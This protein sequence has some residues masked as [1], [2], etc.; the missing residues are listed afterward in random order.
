MSPRTGTGLFLTLFTTLALLVAPAFGQET[1]QI[2]TTADSDYYGFD[3]RT[4]RDV[5]LD[6]CKAACLADPA[7]RAF[8]FNTSAKWCFLKSDYNQLN[9]FPGAIAGKVETALGEP[10]IG[11][12][13]TLSFVPA[14]V[15]GDAERLRADVLGK[16]NAG[17]AGLAFLVQAAE[18]AMASNDPRAALLNYQNALAILPDDTAIWAGL[19]AAANAVV[20]RSGESAYYFQRLGTGAAINAYLLS[21]TAS[22]RA[23]ALNQL[24][25]ALEKRSMFRP[26][27]TAYEESLALVA[28]P[29]IQAL[30]ADL[31]RRK[32]FRVVEHTIDSD[33]ATPR[34]CVQFSED[35]VKSGIDYAQ[36]V[37]V[38]NAP[39]TAVDKG[40]RQLCV[41]GL[42]HGGRYRIVIRQGLPAAIG[43][44]I[45]EPVALDIYVRDRSPSIRFT[46][47]NFV[48]PDSARRGIPLVS[49]NTDR[50]EI[51]LYRIGARS[52]ARLMGES[53]FLRQL[54]AYE[55]GS[56][57]DDLGAPV[58]E[59]TINIAADRNKEVITSFPVDEAVPEREP[60]VYVMT[61]V[62]ENDRRD[63][64][65]SRA[66]QWF[67]VSD[68]GLA[69]FAGEDGL[70]VFARSLDSAAP[71]AGVTL[72]LVARN[73]EVLATAR[74][75]DD[76][77]ARFDAGLARGENGLAPAVITAETSEDFVFL[78]M[79]RA[80]FDLSDRGVTGRPSP[81]ALDVY[82]WTERG[83]YRAG[84]TVHAAALARNPA[85]DAID[86]LPLTFIF[87]RPDGV[88][89]RRIVSNG[90][91]LGGHA[92]DLELTDNAMRGT[93]SLR[94]HADPKEPPLSEK[95]FLVE[96][97]VPDRIAFDLA[98]DREE[99]ALG[100]A[101]SVEV[102]GRYLYGAP[103]EG[104]ALEGQLAI[105]RSREWARFPGY[106]FGLEDEEDVEDVRVALDGLPRTGSDGKAA[107]PVEL[108][109][110]PSTTQLLSA[111]ISVRMVEAGG[112]AVE[113]ALEL[114]VKPEGTSLGLK[115]EFEGGQVPE[116]SIAS[117]RVIAVGPDGARLDAAGLSWSL[118][119]INRQYQWYRSGNSWRYE[120]I[121]S[122]SLVEEGSIDATAAGEAQISV[123]VD[124][125]R[126]RLEIETDDPAGPVTSVEFS[127]GWFVAARSTET[128]DGLEIALD[129]ESYRVG[130]TA[131]LKIES[132]FA[133]EALVTVGSE[134]LISTVTAAVPADGATI[135]IPVTE[136]FGAGTYVTATLFRPGEA[137]E[138]RL[139]MRAI[140]VKWLPVDPGPRQLA[141]ALELPEKTEPRQPL[142]IPLA[143]TGL[144]PGEEA[145]VTVAAVDVGILNLTRY[146]APDP[147][148]W[149]FGQRML[150][151]EMRD[152]YGRLIDGSPGATGRLRTGGDGGGMSP[153]GSPP[154]EK[155]VA[156]FSGIVKVDEDGRATVAFDIPQFNGTAR[157]MAVAWSKSGTG[158][159]ERDIVIRD[160]V[161]LTASL[162]RF[163]APGDQTRLLLEIANT[164][165]P[166]GAYTL[167]LA[168]GAALAAD[169]CAL[170]ATLD[171]PAGG[172]TTLSVPVAAETAGDGAIT[173]TL[174]HASGL[175]IERTLALPVRPGVMPV[176]T[177]RTVALA[178]KGGSLRIDGELLAASIAQGASV[179]V[180]VSRGAAFDVPALLMS[181]DRYPYGCAE[182][183]TS[184]AL[185]LLYVGEL[186]KSAGLEDD[187]ALR[188]RVADAIER[189]LSHQ[190][191]SGSFGLWGPGSGDLWLDA[192]VTDFLTRARE[193]DYHVPAAAMDQ[194]LLNLQNSLAYDVDLATN[195]SEVAYALYVLA[196]NRK[197]S[198]G[199]LRYYSDT[200]LGAFSSPLARAQL[201]A[202]LSLY[203]DAQ[204][205][206]QAFSSALTLARGVE[207]GLQSRADYGSALRDGAAM[208]ALAAESRPEPALVPQMVSYVSDIRKQTR[209]LST[210]DQAWMLLAARAVAGASDDIRLDI[211][212]SPHEGAFSRRLSGEALASDPF[213][214]TNS[215][216]EPVE[217][218]VTT[219]A[220]PEQPLP[221][222]GDGFS[223]ERSYYTLDGKP[224]SIAAARQNERY[225]VVI[226]VR[227]HNDWPSRILVNDLLPA[228][229]EIDNPR[230]VGSAE[231][232]NFEWLGQTNAVHTEFRDDRF[233]AAFTRGQGGDRDYTLAYVVRAVTPGVFV[234][235]AASVEDMY[236]PQL[237]ARTAS[238]FMEV[239]GE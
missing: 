38:D 25:P 113:R 54:D 132:R 11:A 222:G 74:T 189:V 79:T 151:I 115:P 86:D 66:T 76:G 81:G 192:Y 152:L 105:T 67:L 167:G 107:F 85:A 118:V 49:V 162:P 1:R 169:T 19:A 137:A 26:A 183:T 101:A 172:K 110:V 237:S 24:A 186:S 112:R 122:T 196:R 227:E 78:D 182:Q 71:L 135:E 123:P 15:T 158:S 184:R 120:P 3:L 40:A 128:P 126:Y 144:Q 218:V 198:A 143:V 7:C 95:F 29:R 46:G 119:K 147:A 98:A 211:G 178:G 52:L 53:R 235:P 165:G 219:L 210:Q 109:Q 136:D 179:T 229:F 43:E 61:A 42:E 221:A 108:T 175:A 187:P 84:E 146:E 104:L 103:A 17:G 63:S 30:Y 64:W 176:T 97:F 106:R 82:S 203:G 77:R 131:R 226:K 200:Q 48:L 80:G 193:Q 35:L 194:A 142:T 28:S 31:K 202:S 140:G 171:L 214:I 59:G 91:E 14:H 60:G 94:I 89:D 180:N 39:T 125:G 148:G 69:T 23:D 157:V 159:A 72:Q 134:S 216:D 62:P 127:A 56:I 9:P 70:N 150:G 223:I 68:I 233:I 5:S 145:Y 87:Q 83:I 65:D 199:D 234:H 75:D 201:A 10:D 141:V 41:A 117:F 73:N 4:E 160:P 6:Q 230:L 185:P 130:D 55:L 34:V 20:P 236:R 238:G 50:A 58:F 168:T 220:A 163:L 114:G 111:E 215:G 197:A 27:I 225:V 173:L 156:F 228:G 213:V 93:W 16:A 37:R 121:V 212:G 116:G 13:K 153:Q 102:D 99:I 208:L 8:T 174:S 47:D 154:T 139:P 90:A 32:G 57:A 181:L 231:L 170:P 133:G 217:A 166:A 12:P 164:D 239:T 224:A 21:R 161:V 92:V 155:L 2:V 100:E 22:Q 190:A 138:T 149:Y 44:V 96:D 232:K 129:K 188:G 88:E 191:S 204:R 18:N 177:R 207:P 45:A 205:A 195:G 51:A 206:G 36:F 124:W 209:Y 33:S